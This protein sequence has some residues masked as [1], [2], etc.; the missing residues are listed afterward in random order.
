[1]SSVA[2]EGKDAHGLKLE[3]VEICLKYLRHSSRGAFCIRVKASGTK[4]K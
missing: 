3:K 4:S 1:M 2:K